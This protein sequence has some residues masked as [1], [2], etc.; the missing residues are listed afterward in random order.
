[1]LLLVPQIPIGASNP[2]KLIKLRVCRYYNIPAALCQRKEVEKLQ[3][4]ENIMK[5]AAS[6]NIISIN[7]YGSR[8]SK[9]QQKRIQTADD[10]FA[11]LDEIKQRGILSYTI[12]YIEAAKDIISSGKQAHTNEVSRIFEAMEE[13][14][15]ESWNG[16]MI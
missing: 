10:K 16:G 7:N 12:G 11:A 8:R 2:S 15:N 4:E 13:M 3:N 1:M 14:I 5:S 9:K 6:Y